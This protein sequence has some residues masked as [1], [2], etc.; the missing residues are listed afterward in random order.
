LNDLHSAV[1][2][3]F[4]GS[5]N[6]PLNT[7]LGVCYHAWWVPRV[8]SMGTFAPYPSVLVNGQ[9]VYWPAKQTDINV[10]TL[11]ILTDRAAS[12]ASG[13]PDFLGVG[14]G[15]P[16]NGK[17]KSMNLLFGDGHVELHN[18][19]EVQMRYLGNYN[20]YNFY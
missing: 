3:V 8:G 13:N 18:A 6:S 19:R 1:V 16:Y 7:Q 5:T 17:M 2:R 20:W 14:A 12:N 10:G 4:S 15:H 9:K 11:P